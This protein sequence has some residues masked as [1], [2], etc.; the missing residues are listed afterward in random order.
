MIQVEFSKGHSGCLEP[1]AIV[2]YFGL[3]VLTPSG[4]F[5]FDPKEEPN[6]IV[7]WGSISHDSVMRTAEYVEMGHV[8]GQVDDYHWSISEAGELAFCGGIAGKSLAIG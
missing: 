8:V 2:W 6:T 1:K 4:G 5:R 7:R 3:K